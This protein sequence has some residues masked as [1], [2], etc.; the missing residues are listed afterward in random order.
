MLTLS[1]EKPDS[2]YHVIATTRIFE[3]PPGGVT[4]VMSRL[5]R[6]GTMCANFVNYKF[7][8]DIRVWADTI[9]PVIPENFALTGRFGS[10]GDLSGLSLTLV[11][12][13]ARSG[14]ITMP[15]TNSTDDP[16]FRGNVRAFLNKELPVDLASKVRLNEPLAKQ[17]Y[18]LWHDKLSARGWLAPNWPK[19]YGGAAWTPLQLHIFEEE[20][21][22][23]F[24]PRVIPFG[25]TMLGPVLQ[26]FGS[27]A[28]Q[29]HWLPRILS[30]D[31]WWCQGYSEP[32]AGSD[33]ASL[34]TRAER[35][36]GDYIV[37]GQKTWTSYAQHANM[38]FCL[39]RTDPNAKKQSGISFLLIDMK[40]PG[41]DIRPIRLFDNSAEVNEVWFSDVR[42]PLENLVGEENHG[43]TYAKYLLTHERTN[44]S[45]IGF[46]KAGLAEVKRIASQVRERGRPLLENP[47][48]AA[49]VAQVEIDLMAMSVTNLRLISNA[50]AGQ[51][52][53]VESSLL[54][55]K[56]TQIRQEITD[57]ARR[58]VG[59]AAQ[60]F[61][62][63]L[64]DG[65]NTGVPDPYDAGRVAASYFNNRKLSIF[66][67]S[68]EIQ[69]EIYSRAIMKN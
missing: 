1:S 19:K 35:D 21:A 6:T 48:F 56:G 37:N 22:K 32:N 54:K 42:V 40:S 41:I 31:D 36:G 7:E 38:M 13:T 53:G 26:K 59:P 24:A 16:A 67:G 55:I 4:S 68:N 45:G 43:W 52:P 63:D 2:K 44:I 39:V 57:L 5:D 69:R 58:A 20:C 30:G 27:K 15:T 51:A 8:L 66:G 49:R 61:A 9:S 47:H 25:I 17:D 11:R 50:A 62:A 60:P 46:S 33:L 28:Q 10:S 65:A 29:D 23:A 64:I 3:Q 12:G 34:N 18:Q 14:H